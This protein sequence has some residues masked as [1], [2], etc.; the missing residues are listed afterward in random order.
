M[1]PQ[2]EEKILA[3]LLYYP[4]SNRLVAHL[5]DTSGRLGSE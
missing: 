1:E 3:W 4:A 2:I 5:Y